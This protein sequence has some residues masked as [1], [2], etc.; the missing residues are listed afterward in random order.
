MLYYIKFSGVKYPLESSFNPKKNELVLCDIKGEHFI[1]YSLEI[2]HAEL[3]P[4]GKI[5]RP[6]YDSEREKLKNLRKDEDKAFKFCLERIVHH[7]LPM[8]LVGV[9]KEWDSKRYKFHFLANKRVDFRE[10][11]KDLKEEFNVTIELRHIGVRDYSG[12]LGGLGLCGRPFC[13]KTFLTDKE[14]IQ[15]EDARE[16]DIYVNPSKISGPC[17]RL[18]CCLAYEHEF[19]KDELR[20]FPD[21][22]D[23]VIT[24]KGMSKV[25]HRNV[26]INVVTVTYEDEMQEEISLTDLKK[27]GDKW[28]KIL[29]R[30]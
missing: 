19:Y 30:K 23:E 12:Y 3:K 29:K 26:I 21:R 15:L 13:C 24:E 10:L 18:L 2:I 1:G 25:L 9:D 27:K 8:K 4:K 7:D 5:L 22:G 11:V 28:V 6:I 16:Q 17:G 20:K 14:S